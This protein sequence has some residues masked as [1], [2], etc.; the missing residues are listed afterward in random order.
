MGEETGKHY[1]GR[2]FE[3]KDTPADI[4]GVREKAVGN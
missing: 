4:G 3:S 2:W 1:G